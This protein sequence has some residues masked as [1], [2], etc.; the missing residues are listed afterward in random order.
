MWCS[1]KMQLSKKLWL[2]FCMGL[3]VGKNFFFTRRSEDQYNVNEVR[4]LRRS[5]WQRACHA[6]AGFIDRDSPLLWIAR[7]L[8]CEALVHYYYLLL[9]I[10]YLLF[11]FGYFIYILLLY[12]IIIEARPGQQCYILYPRGVPLLRSRAFEHLF[13]TLARDTSP[14]RTQ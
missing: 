12:F 2:T 13:S 11:I 9:F 1:L 5:H 3:R 8:C 10:Y 14:L 4:K 6:F 7:A